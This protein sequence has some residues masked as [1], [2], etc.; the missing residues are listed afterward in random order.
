MTITV[1]IEINQNQLKIILDKIQEQGD[2]II[3]ALSVAEQAIVDRF[4]AATNKLAE[5]IQALIAGGTDNPAF[6]TSLGDI[7]TKL[8]VM[9][10]PSQPLPPAV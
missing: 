3:M 4:N 6:L 2:R 1:N 9:G 8:E 10:S 5:Q 7:A